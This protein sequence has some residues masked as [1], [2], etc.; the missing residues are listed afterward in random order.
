MS[1]SVAVRVCLRLEFTLPLSAEFV[2]WCSSKFIVH[3]SKFTV[4][5]SLDCSWIQRFHC[6]LSVPV[7]NTVRCIAVQR[8]LPLLYH[9]LPLRFNKLRV[10]EVLY[11]AC[12]FYRLLNPKS[13]Y[14]IH[15]HPQPISRNLKRSPSPPN[16][17]LLPTNSFT[18]Q[19]S[20]PKT[21]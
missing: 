3:S 10:L 6:I 4:H 13:G 7:A 14:A 21:Y 11:V 17:P 12:H 5:D 18:F 15:G 8:I 2:A 19:I 20:P 16:S 9:I 1:R